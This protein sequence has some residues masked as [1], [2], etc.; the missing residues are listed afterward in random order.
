MTGIKLPT[1]SKEELLGAI[2]EGVHDAVWQMINNGTSMPCADFYDAVKEGVV[3]AMPW[4]D[5]IMNAI[6][7]GV[8]EGIRESSWTDHGAS[9]RM[10]S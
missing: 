5:Q 1:V 2:R 7:D 6:T 3:K 4:S 8:K 9:P 10:L